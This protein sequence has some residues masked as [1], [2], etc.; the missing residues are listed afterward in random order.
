[1]LNFRQ[2]IFRLVDSVF[3]LYYSKSSSVNLKQRSNLI[4]H[5]ENA[6]VTYR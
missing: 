2:T 1:M 5:A 4:L 3:I 6:D